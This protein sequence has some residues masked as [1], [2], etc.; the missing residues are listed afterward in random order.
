MGRLLGRSLD[1]ALSSNSD[2]SRED[3]KE[4]GST[5]VERELA[6]DGLKVGG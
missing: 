1:A 5:E 3:I 2:G 4:V 6:G